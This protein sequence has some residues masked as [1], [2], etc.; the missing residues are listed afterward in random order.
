MNRD[1]AGQPAATIPLRHAM[2]NPRR[3]P[4][5]DILRVRR[6][7]A[8]R[9]S[10]AQPSLVPTAPDSSLRLPLWS[11]TARRVSVVSVLRE[12]P[13]QPKSCRGP[14]AFYGRC[15][16]SQDL[17]S[18]LDGEA[19]KETQLHNALLLRI[20]LRKFSQGVVER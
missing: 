14:I 5:R 6:D 20:Q 1:S 18:L 15:R 8:T 10:Q 12:L 13:V 2:R 4:S 11:V 16:N 19:S 3:T 17:S 9:P 7:Q